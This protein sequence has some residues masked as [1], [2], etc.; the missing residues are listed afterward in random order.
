MKLNDL[1]GKRFG[2]LFVLNREETK[3]SPGGNKRTMWKC[4]CDCGKE[5]IV[6]SYSLTSGKTT[7]CGCY[8]LERRIEE[9]VKANT[10]HNGSKERL[11]G[12]WHGIL[13]RC[14]SKNSKPY[15]LY[16]GRGIRVCKEWMDYA[17]FREWAMKSGYDPLAPKG[18]CTIDRIDV[19]GDYCPENCRWAD[20]KTQCNNE[21]VNRRIE[22]GGRTQTLTQWA[23]EVGIGDTTLAYRLDNGWQIEEALFKPVR[24]WPGKR[25][26]EN[27]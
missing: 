13:I 21:R 8:Q 20:A 24:P 22:Y 18:V 15:P 2:R 19:N 17:K 23:E 11:Y 14:N 12:I 27:A 7:S 16:G 5:T 10:T 6:W 1:T 26:R 4:K 25:K 3:K 9:S